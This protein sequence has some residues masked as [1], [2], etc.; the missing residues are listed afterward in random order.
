MPINSIGDLA[1][2]FAMR[3]QSNVLKTQLERLS[4]EVVTGVTSNAT[5]HLSGNFSMLS[6]VKHKLAL[7][8]SHRT[9]TEQ[10]R[11]ET[12]VMQAALTRIGSE[13]G[14]LSGTAITLGSTSGTASVV[15]FSNEAEAAL[16][17]ILSAL[18]VSAGG[19]SLFSG[20]DVYGAAVA[21]VDDFMTAIRAAASG[22]TSIADLTA[23][24]DTFFDTPGGDF[25]TL[26][27]QGDTSARASYPL[28]EGESVTL[29]L[30]ADDPVFRDTLKQ[31]ALATLLD[32]PGVTLSD[33]EQT[34]FAQSIGETLLANQDD[35][36]GISADL[37]FAENRIE[38]AATRISSEMTSLNLVQSE[39]LAIDPFEAAIELET[40]QTRLETLYT[41]T[42]RMSRLSLV[43]FLS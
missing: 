18:N 4:E 1:Q 8:E 41:L 16:G 23:A 6:D 42:S 24:M 20:A 28:G 7:L 14:L 21:S 32:D 29:D 40:V 39:L 31:V 26:I 38:R 36:T 9:T 13:A 11:I 10:G 27:Y 12:E 37:G 3:Q 5:K 15:N 19:R 30:R 2:S 17:S 43:N 25:E 35:I 22:A 33:S 34:I